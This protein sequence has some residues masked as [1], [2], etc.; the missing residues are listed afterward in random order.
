MFCLRPVLLRLPRRLAISTAIPPAARVRQNRRLAAG[1]RRGRAGTG[2]GPGGHAENTAAAA[3]TKNRRRRTVRETCFA[4]PLVPGGRGSGHRGIAAGGPAWQ[5]VLFARQPGRLAKT[6]C[7]IRPAGSPGGRRAGPGRVSGQLAALS[8]M[9]RQRDVPLQRRGGRLVA[10][11][12]PGAGAQLA[13]GL[14]RSCFYFR[15]H[16]GAARSFLLQRR[17]WRAALAAPAGKRPRQPAQGR[18][19]AGRHRLRGFDDGDGWPARVCH[20]RQW[21]PGRVQFRRHG[22]L[23]QISWTV[24][25]SLR[26]RHLAGRVG[27]QP[28]HPTGSGR[29]APGGIETAFVAGRQRT[30]FVG[31]RPARAGVVGHAD[32]Y[33]G[34]GQNADH[35]PG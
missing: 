11:R 18:G 3:T 28:A 26:L 1:G 30:G 12:H 7:P 34:G 17:H 15:R 32:R 5:H 24:E 33:R 25:K 10:I 31:A 9:G 13:R 4:R 20:L 35:H 19:G 22:G 21:R 27:K 8:R 16:R 2:R 14:G 6:P 29:R 23:D